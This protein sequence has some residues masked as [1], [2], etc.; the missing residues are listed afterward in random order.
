MVVEIHMTYIF[1]TL[2]VCAQLFPDTWS[3]E[4]DTVTNGYHVHT[5]Q[6]ADH[7]AE[8]KGCFKELFSRCRPTFPADESCVINYMKVHGL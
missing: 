8:R 3:N 2:L 4:Y 5:L 7:S 1:Q 6:V